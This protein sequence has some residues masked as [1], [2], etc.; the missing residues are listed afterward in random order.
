MS[1]F[2]ALAI[3]FAVALPTGAYLVTHDH[4]FLGAI[5]IIGPFFMGASSNRTETPVEVKKEETK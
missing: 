1:P 3:A 5:C 4:G 2:T